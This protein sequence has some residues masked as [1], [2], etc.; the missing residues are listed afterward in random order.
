[1]KDGK[2]RTSTTNSKL[3]LIISTMFDRRVVIDQDFTEKSQA[4]KYMWEYANFS[5]GKSIEFPE[6]KVSKL[7]DF[8][9]DSFY[10]KPMGTKQQSTSDWARTLDS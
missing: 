4:S 1:M 2:R 3:I 5:P 9:P 7:D 8:R 6:P 10:S